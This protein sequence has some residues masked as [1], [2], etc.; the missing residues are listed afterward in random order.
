M[1]SRLPIMFFIS[2]CPD[3]RTTHGSWGPSFGLLLAFAG[4]GTAC[5]PSR[6][7]VTAVER[8]HP[9]VSERFAEYWRDGLADV[10]VYRLQQPRYGEVRT[11]EA[12][13]ITVTEPFDPDALV[14]R[15]NM[16]RPYREV[17]KL[18][19][20]RSFE[21][22]VYDYRTMSSTFVPTGTQTPLKVSTSVQEWCGHV[23][24]ELRW[25]D[26]GI[27][28]TV[29]SYFE[30]EQRAAE[31][32]PTPRD[33]WTEDAFPLVMRRSGGE[34]GLAPGE[35][36]DIQWL[37]ARVGSRLRGDDGRWR[38]ATL[39]RSATPSI[40]ETPDGEV[41]V[42]VWSV[43]TGEEVHR[44]F[45]EAAWPHGVVGWERSD[46]ERGDR[47]GAERID[48]WV[49]QSSDDATIRTSL[50]LPVQRE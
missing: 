45:V 26:T 15:D 31:V 41:A 14:K 21:T 7:S 4:V 35:V 36:R 10:S 11:G 28:R 24:E 43:T 49:R 40:R 23:Y 38:A 48:Y 17:L 20:I 46:G 34:P 13:W 32:L 5:A 19:D 18:N 25:R 33:G 27:E 1:G 6:D 22:G 47:V 37:P 50:G 16:A 8:I 9:E 29:H 44:W 2:H 42:E 39:R 30:T 3:K 12:V